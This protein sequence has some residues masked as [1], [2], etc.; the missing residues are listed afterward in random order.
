MKT[1]PVQK[2]TAAVLA[3]ENLANAMQSLFCCAKENFAIF[4]LFKVT[5]RI[6][7]RN[8]KFQTEKQCAFLD[9]WFYFFENIAIID[10][11][12]ELGVRVGHHGS[13]WLQ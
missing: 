8:K 11:L 7:R 2:N 3:K 6:T 5:L 1:K 12:F 9:Y 10:L 13:K 4:Q